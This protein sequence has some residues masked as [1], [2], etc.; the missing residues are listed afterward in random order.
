MSISALAGTALS[1]V[2]TPQ[3]ITKAA[4]HRAFSNS[5]RSFAD[6]DR[7][8][9]WEFIADSAGFRDAL[10]QGQGRFITT[11][12]TVEAAVANNKPIMFRRRFSQTRCA[13]VLVA[14]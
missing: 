2:S 12:T 14:L 7:S 10:P 13:A 6:R 9:G 5:R 11:I 8:G 4:Q 3:K 1:S